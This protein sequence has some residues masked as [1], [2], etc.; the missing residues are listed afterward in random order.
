MNLF[1]VLFRFFFFFLFIEYL[2]FFFLIY[3][4]DVVWGC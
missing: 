2:G 1:V 4:H 3:E